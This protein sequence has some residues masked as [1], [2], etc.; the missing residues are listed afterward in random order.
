ME[1]GISAVHR[2]LLYLGDLARYQAETE[3]TNYKSISA[4][5]YHQ[6]SLFQLYSITRQLYFQDLNL[7]HYCP[8]E[9]SIS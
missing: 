9:R 6:A 1:E 5:F 3:G 7:M 4:R 2:C 8:F